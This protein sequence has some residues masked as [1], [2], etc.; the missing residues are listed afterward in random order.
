M[1]LLRTCL[2]ATTLLVPLPA[3][4]QELAGFAVEGNTT[5]TG[6][7]ALLRT[8]RIE[9][10]AGL[11]IEASVP[12]GAAVG[13]DGWIQPGVGTSS[14]LLDADTWG[15]SIDG[16]LS[17]VVAPSA[18]GH[19]VDDLGMN[20]PLALG[21]ELGPVSLSAELSYLAL[22]GPDEIS[23]APGVSVAISDDLEL[24]ADLSA[25][26]VAGQ[27]GLVWRY[28]MA[29]ELSLSEDVALSGRW[30]RGLRDAP[31]DELEQLGWLGLTATL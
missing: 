20:V 11:E 4:A 12:G 21:R 1:N 7:E 25:T 13:Y 29:A 27:P 6:S 2:V 16:G 24:G 15:F 14:G 26:S 5:A 22:S 18:N 10:V 30:G 19:G 23:M 28:G 8:L 31:F 17:L 9:N 3:S